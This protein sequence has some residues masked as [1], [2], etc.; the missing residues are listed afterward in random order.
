MPT[1]ALAVPTTLLDNLQASAVL[2]A[3]HG[4]VLFGNPGSVGQPIGLPD[5][6]DN[7][8]SYYDFA[9]KQ[10]HEIATATPASDDTPRRS[11]RA[12]VSGDWVVYGETD[13]QDTHYE[14]WAIYLMMQEKRLIDSDPPH[15]H[16]AGPFSTDGVDVS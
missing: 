12:Q 10:I 16:T 14:I 9:S 2:P 6:P 15:V 11:W 8:L 1:P 5:T 7:A 3:D 13:A 4:V